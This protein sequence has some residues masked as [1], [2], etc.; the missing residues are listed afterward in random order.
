MRVCLISTPT[1]TE[2]EQ[3][4]MAEYEAVRLTSDHAPL[5]ILSLAAV[6][7]AGG[8]TPHVID[9]NQLYYE[10]IRSDEYGAGDFCSFVA[11]RL[12]PLDFDVFG[13]GTICST[14]P[15]TLRLAREVR[16]THPRATI[17]FGGPQASV[18]AEKTLEAFPQ[19]D[20]I[21]RGEAE[22]TLPRLLDALSTGGS[23]D[24][25]AGLTF[26]RNG[27]VVRNSNA[28]VIHDLDALPLPAF[29]LFSAAGKG[30]Y[31]SLEIGR[32]CP[33]ACSF[34]STNDF[35]R[36][37][38]RL[39]SPARAIEHMR[40]LRERYGVKCFELVHDMFTVDRRR[41][42]AFCEALLSSGE[43]FYWSCSA[44][45]DSVDE[46][47]IELMAE[48]GCNS[49][50]FGVDSGSA[51]VQQ[52]INKRLDLEEAARV[53]ECTS[54]L[55]IKSTVSIITGFPEET[56]EDVR[57][58]VNFLADSF[59]FE[60]TDPQLHLLAPLAETP[61]T[62]AYKNELV[63]DDIFSDVSHQGW[64]QDE[65]DREMIVAHPDIFTNFYAIPTRQLG[66]TYLKELKEFVLYGVARLRWLLVMLQ[67]DSGD[68]LRVFDAW[69][70]W[71]GDAARARLFPATNPKIYYATD[72]FR[73][74]FLEFVRTDYLERMAKN[75]RA[76]AALVEY[77]TAFIGPRDAEEETRDEL[78]DEAASAPVALDFRTVPRLASGVR[79]L[80]STLDYKKLIQ[81]LGRREAPEP[82]APRPVPVVLRRAGE[83]LEV[84]QVS[85]LSEKI[86][87]LCDGAR[88]VEQI[89]DSFSSD[90]RE[91]GNIPA[92]RACLF[93]LETLRRQGFLVFSAE[94][95]V[96]VN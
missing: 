25:I 30:Y 92:D 88:S 14:Y 81:S 18:V 83:K 51:A 57:A 78:F 11:R 7:E 21:V 2:Y 69:R 96:V 9:L 75:A 35:F 50:F 90:C 46:E 58:T 1:A 6:L 43:K 8:L 70:A 60:T 27:A 95:E 91:I 49:I 31:M 15:L 94:R 68:L 22:E 56:V 48:A 39:K 34:C 53:I 41:V 16:R 76:V 47:L 29:H 3:P 5:G 38:F 4:E 66:R 52:Q 36:R 54:R 32:G 85:A 79:A 20:M 44:R 87:S 12:A 62:T 26:R 59:R 61:I 67:Q 65:A 40:F 45:T 17:I 72:D 84:L 86:L 71:L 10:Y 93:G 63:F 19:V 74:D 80:R 23:F 37:Q 55:R 42:V 77:E 82:A 28:P 24:S 33:F 89:I 64:Q 73:A 13:F